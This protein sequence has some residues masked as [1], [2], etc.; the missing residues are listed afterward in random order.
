MIPPLIMIM[1]CDYFSGVFKM[2]LESKSNLYFCLADFGF[3]LLAILL[4][5]IFRSTPLSLYSIAWCYITTKCIFIPFFILY[6]FTNLN[7]KNKFSL[8]ELN[9][10]K[11]NA[12]A[13]KVRTILS[14]GVSE[15]IWNVGFIL[16]ALIL[17]KNSEIIYNSYSYFSSVLDIIFG[18][19]YAM[20]GIAF[21][22]IS[23]HL[24]KKEFD[25]AYKEG[26]YTLFLTLLIWIGIFIITVFARDLIFKGMNR[27]IVDIGRTILIPFMIIYLFRFID[28]A[29]SSYIIPASGEVN[30]F[31]FINLGGLVY[32]II[33]FI[34]IDFIKINPILLILL[35]GLD[36][37]IGI[38]INFSYF[39]SKK[40]L[41]NIEE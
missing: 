34:I 1:I 28:W 3:T 23:N 12:S 16:S 30:R 39:I 9:K 24:G 4:A 13:K 40:W 18:L 27:S 10:L 25:I 22:S 15:I 32:F 41:V 37:F 6:A 20:V 14:F 8:L 17:L 21:I 5:S 7:K 11:I 2:L 36:S 26:K 19:F 35:I 31:I 33:L 38:A 29:L